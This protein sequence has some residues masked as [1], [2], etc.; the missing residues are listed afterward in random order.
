MF[1]LT[2]ADLE[3][4]ILGCADGPAAFNADLTARGGNVVSVDPLYAFTQAQIRERI[5]ATYDVILEQL[6]QNQADY[7]WEAI[8]SV[9]VLGQIRMA[10][11]ET[12]L[13]DYEQGQR[14]GRYL[15]GSLPELP[16][17]SDRFDLALVSHFLFLYSDHLSLDFHWQSLQA[18]LRLAPEVRVFP[19]VTLDG[20]PSPHLPTI[21]SR[22]AQAGCEI[23]IQ[24]VAYEFQ[25]GG[26]QMLVIR[27]LDCTE[28]NAEFSKNMRSG[29]NSG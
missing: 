26:N 24:T 4:R 21:T 29:Q 22:L 2:D 23:L 20:R 16:L 8:A 9:E 12:F 17:T 11:M 6:R 19:L 1:A 13:A 5:A 27:S 7:V 25:R 28:V 3:R 15:V 10:A 14:A 18:L